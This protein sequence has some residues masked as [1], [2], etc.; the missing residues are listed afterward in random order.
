MIDI[1]FRNFV[2]YRVAL[3]ERKI[4]FFFFSVSFEILKMKEKYFETTGQRSS[5]AV[6]I[7]HARI[8]ESSPGAFFGR[9]DR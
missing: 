9:T 2:V 6:K 4:F 1:V 3:N 7:F 8:V 5:K